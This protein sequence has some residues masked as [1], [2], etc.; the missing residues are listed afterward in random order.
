MA[1][2]IKGRRATMALLLGGVACGMVGLA[3]GA[4]PLYELFCRVTGYGGTTQVADIEPVAVGDRIITVR[5]NAD[6]SRD[7]PWRFKPVQREIQVRVGEMALA[8]YTAENHSQRSVVGSSTFNVTPLK[9]GPYFNKVD[10]F[11]FEEQELGP[12]ESAEFPVSFFV[13]PEIVDDSGLD[14][15]ST[16]TLSY[17]FFD[18]SEAAGERLENVRAESPVE[19]SADLPAGG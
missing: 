19:T 4:V 1:A 9:A 5:F 2:A 3:F 8:F 15:V 16:I 17:M 14:G 18:R 10:C 11:C 6:V 12:G 7:L 13:D